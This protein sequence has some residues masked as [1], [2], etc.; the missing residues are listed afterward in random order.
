MVDRRSRRRK[1][2]VVFGDGHSHTCDRIARELEA[3]DY[4]VLTAESPVEGMQLIRVRRPD[5]V[6]WSDGGTED[7]GWAVCQ[8]VR[9]HLPAQTPVVLRCSAP[10]PDGDSKAK[11][12]NLRVAIV[13]HSSDAVQLRTVLDELFQALPAARRLRLQSKHA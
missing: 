12:A 1:R 11:A 6:V 13:H 4:H 9:S 3:H 5:A 8:F 7:H 10:S 2:I